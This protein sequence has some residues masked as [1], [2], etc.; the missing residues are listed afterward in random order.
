MLYLAASRMGVAPNAT[1][2]SHERRVPSMLVA[3]NRRLRQGIQED[4]RGRI[5]RDTMLPLIVGGFGRVPFVDHWAI[6][7]GRPTC[8]PGSDDSRRVSNRLRRRLHGR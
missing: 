8:A 2:R 7:L 4:R 1:D 3:T 5:K 6:V